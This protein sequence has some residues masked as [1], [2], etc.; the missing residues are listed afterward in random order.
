MSPTSQELIAFPVAMVTCSKLLSEDGSVI[1]NESE[2]LNSSRG[3][4]VPKV[5]AQQKLTK[6]EMCKRDGESHTNANA[7]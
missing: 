4:T 2:K 6:E 1:S 7:Q 5:T 3:L